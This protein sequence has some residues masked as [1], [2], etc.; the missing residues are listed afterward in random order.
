MDF[1]GFFEAWEVAPG[2]DEF[3]EE[4]VVSFWVGEEGVAG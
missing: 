4:V 2:F 1:E 3:V